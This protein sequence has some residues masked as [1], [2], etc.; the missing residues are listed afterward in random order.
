M[1]TPSEQRQL[2]ASIGLVDAE[3]PKAI[4]G[5]QRDTE[6]G[7]EEQR[8]FY[9]S[10]L[11]HKAARHR[12]LLRSMGVELPPE[13]N[14]DADPARPDFDGGNREYVTQGPEHSLP[15][16]VVENDEQRDLGWGQ[17]VEIEN[18]A[19]L[20]LG[21]DPPKPTP[22]TKN[23]EQGTGDEHS[24]FLSELFGGGGDGQ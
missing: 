4:E 13:P 14:P 21:D 12:G 7:Q 24:R 16:G 10:L 1:K 15:K 2:L 11:D 19:S 23:E 6:D 17:G 9:S 8:E 5:E 18:G 22:P 20:L 3:E